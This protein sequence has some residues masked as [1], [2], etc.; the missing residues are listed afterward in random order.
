MAQPII[1]SNLNTSGTGS[2]YQAILN[3]NTSTVARPTIIFRIPTTTNDIQTIRPAPALP[4]ITHPVVIDGYS[5]Q[6]ATSN[7]LALGDNAFL[8][9]ELDGTNAGAADGLTIQAPNCIVQ[10]LVINRFHRSGIRVQ[11]G[12]GNVIQG[13]FIGT[14]PTGKVAASNW[15]SGITI[16]SSSNITNGG[17]VPGARN[18][19]SA[20]GGHG[21]EISNGSTGIVIQGNFIGTDSTGTN[22]LGNTGAG[23]SISEGASSNFVG[24]AGAGNLISANRTG[25]EFPFNSFVARANIVEGNLIGT[26]VTGSR[27]LG[28][29]EDG[30]LINSPDNLIG[31]VTAGAKNIISANFNSGI[32]ISGASATNNLVLANFIGT[33]DTG[34]NDLGNATDGVFIDASDNAIAFNRIWFNAGN[35]VGMV[36]GSTGNTVTGNSI[37][38]NALSG[39]TNGVL[40]FPTLLSA[41]S[42]NTNITIRGTLTAAAN[43]QYRLEFFANDMGD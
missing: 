25:V 11:S 7:T 5:Q 4:F 37:F 31:D 14:D 2:L 3:A 22:R 21:I 27:L 35:G 26:D 12:D 16:D 20:N 13:N 24:T 30:V 38:T 32:N 19:I 28:N 39:I 23:V 40:S 42:E 9:V 33:D 1:V 6:F 17:P 18:V 36:P 10:G 8:I 15:L 34:T 41:I 29:I 43:S